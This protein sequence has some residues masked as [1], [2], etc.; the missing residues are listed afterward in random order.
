VIAVPWGVAQDNYAQ[1]TVTNGGVVSNAV[2]LYLNQTAPGMFTA[3]QNGIGLGAITHTNG[4]LVTDKNPAQPGETVVAYATGLGTATPLPADGAAAGSNP[5]SNADDNI[6][7]FVNG[8][9]SPSVAFAGLSPGS[10]NLYQINFVV[11]AGVSGDVY[12]D[13]ATSSAVTSQALI[14]VGNAT[15]E[16]PQAVSPRVHPRRVSSMAKH[17]LVPRVLKAHGASSGR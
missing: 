5:P 12:C 13:I 8:V 3:A 1:I 10:V 4:A 14:A 17:P 15:A 7:V 16:Y 9:P 11:P 2:T 6:Q